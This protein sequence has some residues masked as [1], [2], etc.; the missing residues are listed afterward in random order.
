ML[1]ICI[2]ICQNTEE[3]KRIK[4]IVGSTSMR[5]KWKAKLCPPYT[6][7][8]VTSYITLKEK[9]SVRRFCGG[10][11]R[12]DLIGRSISNQLKVQF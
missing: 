4:C 5:S 6:S 1:T 11:T 7:Y 3:E 12:R 10:P 2:V 8:C 9:I